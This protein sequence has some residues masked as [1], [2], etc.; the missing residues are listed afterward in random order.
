MSAAEGAS[1]E[2]LF[3]R[4]AEDEWSVLEVLAHLIDVDY[5]YLGQAQ[6]IHKGR[7]HLFVRFDDARWKAEHASIT[8]ADLARI[9]GD[10]EKSHAA[11][12][13]GLSRISDAELNRT[14]RR[15]DGTPYTVR[16]VFERFPQHDE[17]HTKQIQE[18]LAAV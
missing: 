13:D 5:H 11:V 15:D 12:V 4:P 16:Q 17:N 8:L 7:D 6:A 9:L 14:G 18:I 2:R 1:G 10:L 3:K